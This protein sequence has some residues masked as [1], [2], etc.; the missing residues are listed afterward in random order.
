MKKI[1]FLLFVAVAIIM[2]AANSC[3]DKLDNT[4]FFTTSTLTLAEQLEASPDVLSSYVEILELTGFM[5]AFESYGNYTCFA[6]SNEAISSYINERWGVS[7]VSQLTSDEQLE[8]L[9]Q[10]VQFHTLPSKRLTTSF[11][12]GRLADT[13][14]TGD[15]ITATFAAGGGIQNVL[16]NKEA[17]ITVPDLVVDNGVIH[18]ID[19]VLDPFT[20][21]LPVAMEKTGLYDIF[22]EALKKTGLYDIL[23]REYYDNGS[24]YF[25]TIIAESDAVYAESNI[26]S[27]DDLANFVSPGENNYTS[28]LNPLKRFMLYHAVGSFLYSSDLPDEGFLGTVLENNAIK[29]LKTG[30]DLKINETE[31][32]ENDTWLSL[33][34]PES[35]NPVRNGVYHTVNNV[36]EIFVPRA[37]YMLFDPVSDQPEVQSGAVSSGAKVPSGTYQY[38]SWY[39][40]TNL[41]R[42]L[43]AS[44][45]TNLNSNIWDVGGFVYM[46][47]ITP[48][49][50]KGKYEL[51]GCA[52]GGNNARGIFQVYWDGEP[53]GSVWDV[54]TKMSNV[55]STGDSLVMEAA[56]WRH[57]LA[58]ITNN[59]GASQYDSNGAMRR[60][61]TTELLCPV[62]QRHTLRLVT[63][64]SGGI[65][66]DYFEFIPVN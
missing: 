49:I 59:T 10:I 32:G 25:V 2:I 29:I 7:S 53:I 9:K 51:L 13:T 12:E 42:Y 50:P 11:V 5:S 66:L 62:Q 14:F 6:P 60:I 37:K 28:D 3:Q 23:T 33:I 26:N 35:N 46:E 58:W 40:E 64:K 8:A 61:I 20:D 48:V 55:S 63:I 56:G 47:F 52:N 54:R 24:R 45:Y 4:T 34:I 18:V 41:C 43:R 19:Q 21:M 44:K 39:P 15:Y 17:K 1:K 36:M 38:I 27:F 57:G 30:S 22:I 31:T 16:L 65:P